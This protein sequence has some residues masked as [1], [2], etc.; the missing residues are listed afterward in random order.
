MSLFNCLTLCSVYIWFSRTVDLFWN[1]PPFFY[2]KGHI[3]NH[4]VLL[5]YHVSDESAEGFSSFAI[6]RSSSSSIWLLH[7]V[8][9]SLLGFVKLPF[10]SNPISQINSSSTLLS[11]L[12]L[13]WTLNNNL[14][15]FFFFFFF[16]KFFLFWFKIQ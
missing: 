4:P 5:Q 14:N 15:F 2:D 16:L 13:L 9:Q 7:F 10:S 11:H 8:T 1:N 12:A 3:M 6:P